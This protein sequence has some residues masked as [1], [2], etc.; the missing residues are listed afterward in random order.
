MICGA[1]GAQET[2][3]HTATLFELFPAGEAQSLSKTIPADR[4]IR[5][6]VR[7]PK[8]PAQNGVLVF[9][10]P[11][12]AGEP[13]ED[14]GPVL[15]RAHLIWVAAVGFGNDR[16]RAERVL[17][18]MAAANLIERLQPVDESRVYIA[19]M[20]GGGRIASQIAAR[21]P[22]R[23]VFVT[24]A[25]DFNRRDMKRVFAKYQAAGVKRTLLMDLP[26]LGHE[27]PDAEQLASAIEFLDSRQAG[28]PPI[29]RLMMSATTITPRHARLAHISGCLLGMTSM[30]TM[31][32]TIAST[33]PPA[34]NFAP[35]E[36]RNS[37]RE[38]GKRK[39]ATA[40]NR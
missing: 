6:H 26:G 32:A 13:P 36:S 5:F 40:T 23:Y 30:A 12:S 37:G 27:Y 33:A 8:T 31:T 19:G 2:V 9:V 29:A 39:C 1:A 14:W 3:E 20:S 17:A 34:M 21:F 28:L 4:P 15:D 25:R 35:P 16:P 24:G 18:A 22:N 10:K 38:Y 11:V 7:L